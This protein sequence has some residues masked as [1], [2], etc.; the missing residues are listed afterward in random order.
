MNMKL[1]RELLF[2]L[3][4][5]VCL[6][7]Q[8]ETVAK[9]YTAKDVAVLRYYDHLSLIDLE[10]F[11]EANILDDSDVIDFQWDKQ[12]KNIYVITS[13]NIPG[14]DYDSPSRNE[15]RLYEL[16][17]P[18]G[19]KTLLKTIK[20]PEPQGY[21]G[22]SYPL[23]HLD[24][25]GNPVI[26]LCYGISNPTYMRYTY[27]PTA[28]TLSAP[29]KTPFNNFRDCYK[30]KA[31]GLITTE[32]GKYY[33]KQEGRF[34]NLCTQEAD[35]WER[36][37]TDVEKLEHGFSALEEPLRYCVAPDSS[38][39]LVSFRWDEELSMGSTY[40]VSAADYTATLLSDEEYL[41]EE[42]IPVWLSSGIMP[43]Y[44]PIVNFRNDIMPGISCVG[45]DG[46]V[47]V[48]KAWERTNDA[49]LAMRVRAK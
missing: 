3:L 15:V 36:A 48:M 22:Y 45:K 40:A 12:G 26:T 39:L 46:V 47:S 32:A 29:V 20:V 28:K 30:R 13:V 19:T 43:Y 7:M 21:E 31:Q 2:C 37:I 10:S 11:T 44:Q 34:Y 8:A 18:A 25:K 9:I 5:A 23:L 41:G 35:G 24:K 38:Y 42:F 27:D 1:K 49:P 16:G 6:L 14:P 17:F 33:N 4:I